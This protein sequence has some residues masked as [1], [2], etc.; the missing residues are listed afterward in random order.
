M[1]PEVQ[2]KACYLDRSRRLALRFERNVA[3]EPS[4]SG[5]FRVP[6]FHSSS[7]SQPVVRGLLMPLAILAAAGAVIG[8]DLLR[9]PELRAAPSVQAN[10]A[11]EDGMVN[12]Q[13]LIQ[14]TNPYR[15]DT[16]LDGYR[17]LEEFARHSSP[18]FPQSVPTGNRMRVGLSF[19]GGLDSLHAFIAVYLPDGDL[20]E[21]EVQAG[22]LV[23]QRL[24][25]FSQSY[26]LEH[27]RLT[28]HGAHDPSARVVVID[29][30]VSPRY[31]YA[32]G[33]ISAFAAVRDTS[34]GEIRAAD[35]VH[36]IAF[37]RTIVMQ[38]PNPMVLSTG[39][40]SGT[41]Q[42]TGGS[43]Q[44]G[45]GSIYVPLP[46]GAGSDPTTW[47]PGQ[48]C[49]QQTTVVA[50]NGAQITQEVVA[51][52]CQEGWDGFCPPTCTATVGNTYDTID[53][54]ALIGG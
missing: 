30:P 31:V 21:R 14:G 23:G 32:Y 10:D 33:N 38:M 51:A 25:T 1:F 12:A 43:G 36:L 47:A 26:V 41:G 4:A 29:M 53:P 49:V 3:P 13:E 6:M 2:E 19:R 40:L 24:V 15:A 9:A 50:V 8:L 20:R 48:V 39:S 22:L 45:I 11:D 54:V 5:S 42:Q 35:S 16:D 46:I 52:E 34:T 17:D 37:G 7:S 18:L 44:A 28:V 27:A